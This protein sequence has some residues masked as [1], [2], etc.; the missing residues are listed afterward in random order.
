MSKRIGLY[1]K[2]YPWIMIY[3]KLS[4]FF[5]WQIKKIT[6]ENMSKVNEVNYSPLTIFKALASI[7]SSIYS[8]FL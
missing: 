7:A 3:R 1:V 5:Y 4:L 2:P 6:F 8:L